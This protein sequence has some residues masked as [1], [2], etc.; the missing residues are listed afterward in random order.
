MKILNFGSLNVDY[1]YTLD[2]IVLEGE[3]I[4]SS[5]MQAF[6]GGKG[7]N[8]S[9]AL[10]RAGASVYHAGLI[11][12]DGSMLLDACKE[13][14]VHTEYIKKLSGKSGHTIIQVDKNAQNSII[15][16]GGTNQMQTKEYVDEVLGDFGEGDILLLQNEINC[17]EYIIEKAYE[18]GM[19]IALNPS[20]LDDKL[21]K[22]ALEKIWLFMMNE[23]E[24]E[25]FAGTSDKD[26]ILV[27]LG[28]K[29]PAAEFVLTLGEEGAVYYDRTKKIKQN[30][31]QVRAVDTTAAG[32]TFTG[33]YLAS[34][35][36]GL[37]I[38]EALKV[39]S[40]AAAIAVSRRGAAPS[41]PTME[42]VVKKF[43]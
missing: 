33:F 37:T 41:I 35:M 13:V 3:T 32:D 10:A 19:K 14:G 20:P 11:G 6:C 21:K 17:M 42:E 39:A 25:Q 27:R 8:Q 12:E 24:G 7:L 38:K 40:K 18:Q 29:Y 1:V 9:I 23:I 28:E 26:E 15:L 5:G 30:I 22:C 34:I 4:L 2:H 16:Y 36:G 31:F 43:V